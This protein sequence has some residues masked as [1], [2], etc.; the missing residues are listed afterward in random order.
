MSTLDRGQVGWSAPVRESLQVG[1]DTSG[2]GTNPALGIASDELVRYGGTSVLGETPEIYGAE[3]LL[4]RRAVTP[5]VG[6]KLI[7]LIRWWENHVQ[8]HNSSIDNNP[9]FGNKQGGLTTI[10]EKSLGAETG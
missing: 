7:D 8:Q 6:E 1:S 3:H 5:Q 10:F 9:S 2:H 4:I